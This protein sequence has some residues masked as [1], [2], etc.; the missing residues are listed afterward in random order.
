MLLYLMQLE[1]KKPVQFSRSLT[2]RG[3]LMSVLA[4]RSL[5]IQLLYSEVS[6]TQLAGLEG[7]CVYFGDRRKFVPPSVRL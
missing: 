3:I 2:K 6:G 7:I 1:H 5:E 4:R